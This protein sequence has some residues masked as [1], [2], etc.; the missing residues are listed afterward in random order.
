LAWVRKIPN[1]IGDPKCQF[2]KAI[3]GQSFSNITEKELEATCPSAWWDKCPG[4]C[5]CYRWQDSN[6]LPLKLVDCRGKKIVDFVP[7]GIP[8]EVTGLDLS[9]NG[10]QHF[11]DNAFVH[12]KSLRYLNLNGKKNI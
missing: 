3:V 6:F 2:P 5:I 8:E 12:L 4:D 11:K 7:Y 9:M 1:L 10:I